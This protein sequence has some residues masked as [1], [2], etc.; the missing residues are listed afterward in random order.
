LHLHYTQAGRVTGCAGSISTRTP[1]NPNCVDGGCSACV[2]HATGKHTSV[3]AHPQLGAT[4]SVLSC[5]CEELRLR[6][7]PARRVV[8]GCAAAVAFRCYRAHAAEGCVQRCNRSLGLWQRHDKLH[9]CWERLRT[10]SCVCRQKLVS[11]Q[12]LVGV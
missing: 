2:V 5:C 11:D 6:L 1:T 12:L 4:G 7:V 3:D 8:T 10:F 9:R